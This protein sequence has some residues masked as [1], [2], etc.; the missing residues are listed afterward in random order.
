L[1]TGSSERKPSKVEFYERIDHEESFFY[2][3]I[4]W[5]GTAVVFTATGERKVCKSFQPVGG[6]DE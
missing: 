1:Y 2:S 4:L 3:F 6:G 5:H